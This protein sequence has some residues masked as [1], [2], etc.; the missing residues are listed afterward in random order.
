MG[1]ESEMILD[2]GMCRESQSMICNTQGNLILSDLE[3]VEGL[4]SN[5]MF[6]GLLDRGIK[7]YL[8]SPIR[9]NGKIIGA[10]ELGSP[11]AND[12]NSIVANK[13][14][15]LLPIFTVAAELGAEDYKTKLEAIVQEKFTAIHP[16][17]SWR[18]FEVAE[19]ALKAKQRG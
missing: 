18:F 10:L 15:D 11:N 17:V 16:S 4:E 1:D 6:Q 12:L 9:P 2:N 7:S 14:L 19:N 3:S 5:P 13:L 8:I